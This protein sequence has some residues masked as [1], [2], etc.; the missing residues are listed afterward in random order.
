MIMVKTKH[1]PQNF[2][3]LPLYTKQKQNVTLNK[4]YMYIL[5]L[6]DNSE[7]N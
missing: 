1:L 6:S 7:N 4:S 3:K 2:A 5:S